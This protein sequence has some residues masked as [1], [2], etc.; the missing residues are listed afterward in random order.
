MFYCH[1]ISGCHVGCLHGRNASVISAPGWWWLSH[2]THE[3]N[4][5]MLWSKA[6]FPPRSWVSFLML[7]PGW[8]S[9]P[10]YLLPPSSAATK[11]K[12]RDFPGGPVVK[13]PAANARGMG[14]SL[15]RELRSHRLQFSSV[16]QSYLTLCNPKDCS[17][18]GLP[19]HQ[20]LPEVTQT[21]AHQVSDAIQ[22][23]HPL[24]SPSPLTFHLSQHQ[25]LFKWVTSSHQVAEVL[26][27]QLQH[28]SFQWIFRTDF[29]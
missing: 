17:M 5:L 24:S 27:F 9:I 11:T 3:P 7:T 6:A 28:Q 2:V 8:D 25:G 13:T 4:G 18:P 23:S 29:L 19:V 1:N 15:V 12:S 22:P 10:L 16:A 14:S 26:E 20:Q 21:H